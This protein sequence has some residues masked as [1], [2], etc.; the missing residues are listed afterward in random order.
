MFWR[1]H[2][3]FLLNS[4][5]FIARIQLYSCLWPVRVLDDSNVALERALDY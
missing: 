4:N 1:T 2:E 5:D 3:L